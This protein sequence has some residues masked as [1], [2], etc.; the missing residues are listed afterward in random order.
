[1]VF[2]S[3]VLRRAAVAGLMLGLAACGS[4]EGPQAA[5]LAQLKARCVE[6]MVR[7]TCRVVDGPQ[8]S[9]AAGVVFVAGVGAVDGEAYRQLRASGEAMCGMA[10]RQCRGDWAS[11]GCR[12]A[13]SLWLTESLSASR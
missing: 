6:A 4:H 7:S 3:P 8:A 10:E 11:P 5:A 1:M 13:R 2:C 9:T 12:T